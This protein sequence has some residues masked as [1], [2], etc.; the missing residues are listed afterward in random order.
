MLGFQMKYLIL[1]SENCIDKI[2]WMECL[3]KKKK[4]YEVDENI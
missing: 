4:V 2:D 1:K 3:F